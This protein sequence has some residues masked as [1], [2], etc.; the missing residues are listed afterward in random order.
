MEEPTIR[1]VIAD[2]SHL[3]ALAKLLQAIEAEDR[4]ENAE[5]ALR[6]PEGMRQSLRY[7]DAL[8]SDC[9]WL[10]IAL[11][12]DQ[13]AGLAVL[14]RIPK[15]DAR[16]GFLYLDELHVIRGYQRQ[17]IGKL[18]LARCIEL[19]QELGLSGIRLLARMDNEPARHLYESMNF[20]GN[21]TILYQFRFDPSSSQP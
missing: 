1:V 10:L 12:G 19:A 18:L 11:F 6:A 21:E 14:T 16:L 20:Q 13:P 3:D 7:F 17:G 15:L 8:N 2:E 9:V 5:A 4:P